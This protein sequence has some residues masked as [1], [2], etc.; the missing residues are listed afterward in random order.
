MVE[1][2]SQRQPRIMTAFLGA[3]PG[4]SKVQFDHGLRNAHA[5]RSSMPMLM[6]Q[7]REMRVS[8]L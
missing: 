2:G 6:V 1:L 3:K 8:V 7:I 4:Q 5:G